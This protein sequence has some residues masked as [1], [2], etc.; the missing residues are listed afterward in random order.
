MRFLKFST[1]S[2][3]PVR[4]LWPL[5]SRALTNYGIITFAKD[6][7]FSTVFF[8]HCVNIFIDISREFGVNLDH[9]IQRYL[10]ESSFLGA[11]L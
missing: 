11:I 5:E 9:K 3:Y 2:N 4:K 7:M 1:I 6:I 10:W 8:V